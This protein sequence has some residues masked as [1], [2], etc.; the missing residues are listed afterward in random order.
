MSALGKYNSNSKRSKGSKTHS[1]IQESFPSSFHKSPINGQSLQISVGN[2]TEKIVNTI[3]STDNSTLGNTKRKHFNTTTD[4]KKKYNKKFAN[5]LRLNETKFSLAK[6]DDKFNL[7][8]NDCMGTLTN[9]IDPFRKELK[10]K[11][12]SS[13]HLQTEVDNYESTVKGM[14]KELRAAK[15]NTYI[16]GKQSI[17]NKLSTEGAQ[18][19]SL[20]ISKEI[21]QLSEENCKLRNKINETNKEKIKMENECIEI[22]QEI[23]EMRKQAKDLSHES[24]VLIEEKKSIKSVLILMQKKIFELKNNN[25]RCLN[26]EKAISNQVNYIK[27]MLQTKALAEKI[28]NMV[29]PQKESV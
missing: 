2:D 15:R 27:Q 9:L 6:A 3:C 11:E 22:T 12:K 14:N 28:K 24:N 21:V 4:W 1:K 7:T 25:R 26:K 29:F 8:F 23:D 10:E 20:A 5:T 16:F 17:N 18:K 19:E 13:K